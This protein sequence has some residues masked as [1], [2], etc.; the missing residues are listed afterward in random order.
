MSNFPRK[1]D[2]NFPLVEVVLLGQ[3]P[4]DIAV[5]AKEEPAP[6]S[7]SR[8]SPLAYEELTV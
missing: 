2:P 3:L 7:G 1:S 4:A 8:T 6:A 5:G